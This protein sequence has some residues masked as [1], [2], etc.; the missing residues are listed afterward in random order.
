MSIILRYLAG[1]LLG[2]TLFLVM[3]PLG[4]YELSR[5]DLMF[6]Q[7]ILFEP[8][9]IRIMIA[10]LLFLP[11]AFFLVWS[12]FF[13]LRKGRG[14]PAEGMGIAVSP[15]TKK[16]VTEG[17]YRYSRNPMVLGAFLLYLSLVVFLNSL[18]SLLVLLI[19]I[20]AGMAYLKLSEEKRLLRDFGEEYRNYRKK[21]PMLLPVRWF[22]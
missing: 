11:G 4:L 6:T 19:F 8:D 7:K 5:L 20:S 22:K 15:R 1:Y 17:P 21:V 3:I 2:C 16:L 9:F 10:S 12:N 14:G 13:L 18:F